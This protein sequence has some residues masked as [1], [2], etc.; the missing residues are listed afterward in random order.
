LIAT[1]QSPAVKSEALS[2]LSVLN[3]SKSQR[4]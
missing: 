1:E 3:E 4:P 2:T